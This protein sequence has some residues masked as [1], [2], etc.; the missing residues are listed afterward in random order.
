MV[1]PG[2]G[3]RPSV[4]HIRRR[5]SI[6]QGVHGGSGCTRSTVRHRQPLRLPRDRGRDRRHRRDDAVSGRGLRVRRRRTGH[7][8]HFDRH[9]LVT[10]FDLRTGRNRDP[11]IGRHRCLATCVMQER[12]VR[13]SEVGDHEPVGIDVE[14][15]VG[16][17]DE[18]I[19]IDHHDGTAAGT[20][21]TA[22]R[23]RTDHVDRQA[24]G[25]RQRGERLTVGL[26]CDH[27]S[28]NRSTGDPAIAAGR[29][30]AP[31]SS[32]FP[33]RADT[34]S[35]LPPEDPRGPSDRSR[36]RAGSSQPTG[37]K[38]S[39]RSPRRH[40]TAIRRWDVSRRARGSQ[41]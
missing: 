9:P 28:P 19:V 32:T 18:R 24:P 41:R 14:R 36:S 20:R 4:C 1:R 16:F 21:I 17:R 29:C 40:R 13:R 26:V 33:H 6:R 30:P 31:C 12:A 38:T 10:E 39:V 2:V 35:L 27:G 15:K 22:D 3:R 25:D 8:G 5:I 7:G 23:D 34:A 37:S 11:R